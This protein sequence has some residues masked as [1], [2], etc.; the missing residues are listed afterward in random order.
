VC[1]DGGNPDPTSTQG[2]DP[3]RAKR[4]ELDGWEYPRHLSGRAYA[5]VAHGDTEGADIVRRSLSDWLDEM[6]LVRAGAAATIDRYVGYFE[7]YAT[8]HDALDADEALLEEARNAARALLRQV[9]AT[10][11]GQ[12][13]PDDGLESPRPK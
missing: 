1:A 7:P 2:K 11:G 10:R 8:S 3:A 5:I 12:R 9:G 4:I 13:R 6:E